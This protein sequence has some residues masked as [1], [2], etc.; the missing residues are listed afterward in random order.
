[1]GEK[2]IQ[3]NPSAQHVVNMSPVAPVRSTPIEIGD[4]ILAS[5][6][7]PQVFGH[8]LRSQRQI[9][10]TTELFLYIFKARS[11]QCEKKIDKLNEK[12]DEYLRQMTETNEKVM[13]KFVKQNRMSQ[14]ELLEVFK[15]S[16]G[17][18]TSS[19]AVFHST[20]DK[21]E[22]IEFNGQNLLDLRSTDG[23]SAFGRVLASQM[24]GEGKDCQLA[25][26]RL[27]L[28]VEKKNTR[29]SVDPELER[30]F[31]GCMHKIVRISIP[32]NFRK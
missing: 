3:A 23:P 2:S 5:E 11:C 13:R 27:G 19:N 24:F 26:Q 17:F 16:A 25:E 28:R 7:T 32:S 21:G 12:V 10:G 22:A 4:S 30:T 8:I 14:N 31:K 9:R 18:P 15:R 1:M 20:S 6:M 29:K